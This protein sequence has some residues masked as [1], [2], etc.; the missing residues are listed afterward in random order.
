MTA[1]TAMKTSVREEAM[2][3]K[4]AIEAFTHAFEQANASSA[5]VVYVHNQQLIQQNKLGEIVVLKN[6]SDAYVVP[7]LKHTVLKRK[8]KH[9]LMA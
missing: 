3:P 4:L 2:I 8:K 1:F 6:V 9:E 5:D 7:K